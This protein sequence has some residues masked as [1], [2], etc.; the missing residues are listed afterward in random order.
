[1]SANQLIGRCQN[2]G[3]ASRPHLGPNS[4][5]MHGNG[6]NPFLFSEKLVFEREHFTIFDVSDEIDDDFALRDE[7]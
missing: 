2:S 1:M 3:K 7:K 6:S 5:N 4:I